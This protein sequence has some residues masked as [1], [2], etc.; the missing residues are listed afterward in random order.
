MGKKLHLC[1]LTSKEH[2]ASSSN[3]NVVKEPQQYYHPVTLFLVGITGLSIYIPA[4]TGI[5]QYRFHLSPCRDGGS[6]FI[7]CQI[8]LFTV[9]V[10]K[11]V[12][13][14][15]ASLTKYFDN[16]VLILLI[17]VMILI[18]FSLGI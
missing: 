17:S 13:F 4:V 18:Y 7:C 6:C 1:S 16:Y 12:Y 2:L 3:S 5:S 15:V 8:L 14:Y 9:W 10:K 11:H